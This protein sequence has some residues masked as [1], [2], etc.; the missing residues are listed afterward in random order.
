MPSEPYTPI[1]LDDRGFAATCSYEGTDPNSLYYLPHKGGRVHKWAGVSP[2][3]GGAR[4][5]YFHDNQPLYAWQFT[6]V[7]YAVKLLKKWSIY[8]GV[9][10]GASGSPS[11]SLDRFSERAWRY[12]RKNSPEGAWVERTLENQ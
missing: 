7:E 4:I 3:P 2:V 10:A 11:V 12:D 6:S 9:S 8:W 5:T 1:R